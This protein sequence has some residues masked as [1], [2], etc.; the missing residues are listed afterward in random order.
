MQIISSNLRGKQSPKKFWS[1]FP[2][3]HILPYQ[4]SPMS[5]GDSILHQYNVA[6]RFQKH[7]SN[8][9]TVLLLDE[10]GLAE[11]SPDMPLKVLHGMLV[12]PPIAI[13]GLSNWV[14]DPAKMNRAVLVQRPEPSRV[15][16]SLT[17]AAILGLEFPN[18][19]PA[20]SSPSPSPSSLPS[21]SSV[22][23]PA[24]TSSEL[25]KILSSLSNGFFA[26]NGEQEGRDFIGM[27][28][29][30][31]LM[32]YLRP[33]VITKEGIDLSASQV[34]IEVLVYAICRNFGGR[35]DLLRD[36]LGEILQNLHP[37]DFPSLTTETEEL[38]KEKE[39]KKIEKQKEKMTIQELEREYKFKI[40]G[41]LALI[42]DNLANSSSRHLMLLTQNS[43]ALWLLHQCHLVNLNEVTTLIG[44]D[45]AEDD[46]ELYV[47]QQLNRVKLAMA[48]GG[49][50]VMMNCDNMYEALYDIL[51]QR[52]LLKKVSFFFYSFFFIPFPFPL[53]HL[54]FQKNHTTGEVEKL[55]RLAIGS[56][57]SLCHVSPGFKVVVVVE[58]EV[59]YRNLDLPLLNRFEKQVRFRFLLFVENYCNNLFNLIIFLS[60]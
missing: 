9:I 26:I 35:L 17:G 11:H 19:L 4:C 6:V 7:A 47:I 22:T 21:S 8:T 20:D 42:R 10:V 59:A 5:D 57:S 55:L 34:S 12:D 48:K 18:A 54:D 31:C 46:S 36:I 49:V 41:V 45:F 16:I 25:F 29:Y 37:N 3:I 2:G 39:I 51:N 24:F 58:K 28:D 23:S 14:L 40:P 27:R 15:D 56:R 13:V 43:S 1:Q 52:Y 38:L 30:Y 53:S 60:F 44:S 33:L 50:V 32:K